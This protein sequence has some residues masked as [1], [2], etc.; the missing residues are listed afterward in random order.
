MSIS[1]KQSHKNPSVQELKEAAKFMADVFGIKEFA[2]ALE[3]GRY[4]LWKPEPDI[5]T[6]ELAV[7]MYL[8][9]LIQTGTYSVAQRAYYDK[10]PPNVQRHFV[11]ESYDG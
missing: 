10:M 7:C 2:E 4:F 3:D 6:F 11:V 9:P 1:T 8:V 5:T